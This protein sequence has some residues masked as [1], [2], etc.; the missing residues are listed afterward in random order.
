M[1]IVIHG[2]YSSVTRDFYQ[3]INNNATIQNWIVGS[4]LWCYENNEDNTL[5]VE[6]YDNHL[7]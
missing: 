7:N 1:T 6:V 5:F 4:T 3:E 2:A